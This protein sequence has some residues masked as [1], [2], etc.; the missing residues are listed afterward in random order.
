[1]AFDCFYNL[2]IT[3]TLFLTLKLK[4]NHMF[5]YYESGHGTRNQRW[6]TQ[7]SSRQ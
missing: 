4:G 5:K 1:M 3:V 6:A 2:F 7:F